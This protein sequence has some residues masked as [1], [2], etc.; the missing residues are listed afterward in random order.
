MALSS[1]GARE[2]THVGGK[3]SSYFRFIVS[4]DKDI[5]KFSFYQIIIQYNNH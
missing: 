5:N 4:E 2:L 3:V 1:G